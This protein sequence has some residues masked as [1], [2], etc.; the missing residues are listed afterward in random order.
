M[1]TQDNNQEP[2]IININYINQEEPIQIHKIGE[3]PVLVFNQDEEPVSMLAGSGSNCKMKEEAV[4]MNP[5][6]KD[7]PVIMKR[8]PNKKEEPIHIRNE[9][10]EEP[11]QVIFDHHGGEEP[12]LIPAFNE[13]PLPI[14]GYQL[15]RKHLEEPVM[16][17]KSSYRKEEPAR[18][19]R[20]PSKFE[21]QEC[22]AGE[23]PVLIF[24]G[25]SNFNEEPVKILEFN[26]EPVLVHN[27]ITREE[28][29]LMTTPGK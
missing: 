20:N 19:F 12:V 27:V 16:I 28:P 13:E 29:F 23:E 8:E 2:I 25:F 1:T 24:R 22:I 17:L 10:P 14:K 11:I 3:E 5:H 15:N 21:K 9:G 6:S 18:F 26:E 4:L 7:E